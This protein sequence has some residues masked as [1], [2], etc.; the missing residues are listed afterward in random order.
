MLLGDYL[1]SYPSPTL[2]QTIK[3]LCIWL[4]ARSWSCCDNIW[5]D[6]FGSSH[7]DSI[8]WKLQVKEKG[9]K[10]FVTAEQPGDSYTNSLK[11]VSHVL[12]QF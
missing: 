7:K 11:W 4:K 1:K 6:Q 10:T 8:N 9:N 3:W 2:I 12:G 5:I